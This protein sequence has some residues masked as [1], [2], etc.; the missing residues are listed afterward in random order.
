M[1]ERHGEKERKEKGFISHTKRD[2]EIV[3]DKG[4]ERDSG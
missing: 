3:D 2:R 4:S 1:K